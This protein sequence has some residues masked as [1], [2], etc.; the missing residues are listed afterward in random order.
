MEFLQLGKKMGNYLLI[1]Q[2]M[3]TFAVEKQYGA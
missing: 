2:K 3:P 1:T